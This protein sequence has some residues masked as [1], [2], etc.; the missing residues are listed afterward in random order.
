[1]EKK[2]L[3]LYLNIFLSN[4]I[5]YHSCIKNWINLIKN[6]Y[7]Y[8]NREKLFPFCTFISFLHLLVEKDIWEYFN[9]IHKNKGKKQISGNQTEQDLYIYLLHDL[10]VSL[11]S[12]YIFFCVSRMQGT[13]SKLHGYFCYKIC[14]S[15]YKL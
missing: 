15:K 5:S 3:H 13:I 1:M 4:W 11:L 10:L 12:Y 7:F 8:I 6:T 14:T 9:S 2:T